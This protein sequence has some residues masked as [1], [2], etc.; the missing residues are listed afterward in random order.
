MVQDGETA[1]IGGLTV[2]EVTRTRAGIP[3]LMDLP[4]AGALFR[5]TRNREQ[6]RDLLIMVTPRIVDDRN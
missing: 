6:K 3:V 2:S 4:F 5:T 1:V